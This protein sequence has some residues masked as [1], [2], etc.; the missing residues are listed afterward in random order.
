ME[1]TFRNDDDSKR[2]SSW[3][4]LQGEHGRQI[5][6]GLDGDLGPWSWRTHGSRVYM[7][8]LAYQATERA[9]LPGDKYKLVT[10]LD[11][12]PDDN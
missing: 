12:G 7:G 2:L 5:H 9:L 6:I 10:V 3:T 11:A 4:S 8:R 1:G